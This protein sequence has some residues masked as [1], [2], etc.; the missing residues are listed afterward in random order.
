MDGLAGGFCDSREESGGVMARTMRLKDVALNLDG[1]ARLRHHPA[2]M[3]KLNST[4]RKVAGSAGSGF[5]ATEAQ[6]GTRGGA[7]RP[8]ASVV[9]STHEGRRRQAEDNVLQRA[10]WAGR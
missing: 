5:D 7:P 2:I 3:R 4:A 9:T 1:F 6:P 8:R 10:I